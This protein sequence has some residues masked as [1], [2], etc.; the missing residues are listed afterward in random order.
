MT[1]KTV[2]SLIIAFFLAGVLCGG[3]LGAGLGAGL[4]AAH[5]ASSVQ[6]D[7]ELF[8][9]KQRCEQLAKQYGNDH[10]TEGMTD[11]TVV[12]TDYS[13][14]FHSCIGEF[15]ET[16]NNLTPRVE[17]YIIIDLATNR[18]FGGT[19]CHGDQDCRSRSSDMQKE[20]SQKFEQAVAG[21]ISPLN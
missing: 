20:M 16:H 6:M 17:D 10:T 18:L 4:V 19:G 14:A 13:T 3:G 15:F 5:D 1:N 8:A 11:E 9:N 21:Q 2:V 12:A 7:R